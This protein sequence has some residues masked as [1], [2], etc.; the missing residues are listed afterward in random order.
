MSSTSAGLTWPE[1]TI[2][3]APHD[4]KAAS[5]VPRVPDLDN[6]DERELV[7]E[8]LGG[9]SEAFDV[10]VVRHRRA[11]YLVCYRF[12]GNHEDA[13]DLAQDV[14]VRAYRALGRFKGDSSVKTWLYRIAVN[15]CLNKVSARALRTESID[16]QQPLPAHDPD[17]VSQLLSAERA[18]LVRAAVARLPPRQRATLI[19][20]VYQDLPH[21][22][23]ARIMGISVGAVK[24]NFFHALNNLRRLLAGEPL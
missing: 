17:A 23:I 20:R 10:L 9:R 13:T 6:A 4:P 12:V 15:V 14:F 3:V 24:A 7:R 22:E 8:C 18:G 16:D 11:V 21:L 1:W 2:R 19:L 5:D